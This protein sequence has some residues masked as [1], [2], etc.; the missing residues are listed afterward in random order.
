MVARGRSSTAVIE[1][2]FTEAVTDGSPRRA[3]PALFAP[4]QCQSAIGGE[5]LWW[6][7]TVWTEMRS[8]THRIRLLHECKK[9][10]LRVSCVLYF[11][12]DST[13]RVDLSSSTC[14]RI[15]GTLAILSKYP[16]ASDADMILALEGWDLGCGYLQHIQSE[17]QK[18]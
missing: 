17:M 8:L 7:R 14:A 5:I 12:R 18:T 6:A 15:E 11:E 9:D 2:P 3:V 13:G 10:P 16:W 1:F 4:M